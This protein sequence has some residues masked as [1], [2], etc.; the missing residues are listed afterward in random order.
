MEEKPVCKGRI[1]VMSQHIYM[2][3]QGKD[4]SPTRGFWNKNLDICI[5]NR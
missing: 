5:K 2:A 1:L 3:V 4:Q